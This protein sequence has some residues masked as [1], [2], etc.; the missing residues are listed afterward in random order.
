MDDEDLTK[1]K[2][3]NPKSEVKRLRLTVDEKISLMIF[4][5]KETYSLVTSIID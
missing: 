5:R 4:L 3:I 1:F 2:K